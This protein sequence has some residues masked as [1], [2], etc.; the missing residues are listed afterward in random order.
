MNYIQNDIDLETMEL[1]KSARQTHAQK[2]CPHND[3]MQMAF[4][5]S[6]RV[7]VDCERIF[8]PGELDTTTPSPARKR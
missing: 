6:L 7:C 3:I 4:S 5:R 1:L 8:L 2:D